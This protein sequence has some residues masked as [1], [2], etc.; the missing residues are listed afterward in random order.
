MIFKWFSKESLAVIVSSFFVVK[1]AMIMSSRE[2]PRDVLSLRGQVR[3][4]NLRRRAVSDR[5][6]KAGGAI[7]IRAFS[8][9][10][11]GSVDI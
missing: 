2:A 10:F 9:E 7:S 6:S 5:L 1:F 11:P 4:L 3:E 8:S